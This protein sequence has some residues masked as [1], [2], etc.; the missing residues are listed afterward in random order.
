MTWIPGVTPKHRPD[1]PLDG[2]TD[3]AERGRLANRG[4]A[5]RMADYRRGYEA[6]KD[7]RQAIRAYCLGHR[8]L[9]AQAKAVGNW[10]KERP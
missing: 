5:E 3:P 10:P 8:W 1:D 6:T 7:H 4:T 9:V 2:V